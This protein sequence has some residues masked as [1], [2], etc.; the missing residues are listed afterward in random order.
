[1][2]L[3]LNIPAVIPE[4]YVADSS[5]RL[6]L[7]RRLAGLNTLE[8]IEDIRQEFSDRFGPLPEQVENLLFVVQIKVRALMAGVETIGQ[9]EDQLV[10]RSPHLE[11][12]THPALLRQFVA[13]SIPARTTRRAVWLPIRPN[14][15]WRADLARVLELM[16]A[17]RA[18]A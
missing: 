12:A 3:D 11:N 1:M 2:T 8:A 17:E 15:Q 16:E 7:Y 13:N 6:Q 10:I 5:L 18:G 9:E 14:D 4:T